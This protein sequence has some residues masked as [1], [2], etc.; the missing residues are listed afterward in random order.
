ML[1][2][3]CGG[4]GRVGEGVIVNRKRECSVFFFFKEFLLNDTPPAPFP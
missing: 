3:N 1:K 2:Q 4:G